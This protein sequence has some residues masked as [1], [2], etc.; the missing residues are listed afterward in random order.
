MKVFFSIPFGGCNDLGWKKELFA[1]APQIVGDGL[2]YLRVGHS[3]GGARE[4]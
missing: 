3:A 4:H 1:G 2:E